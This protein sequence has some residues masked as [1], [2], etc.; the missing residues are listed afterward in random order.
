MRDILGLD[1]YSLNLSLA[2]IYR[3]IFPEDGKTISNWHDAG[4]DVRMTIRLIE[5][6][7]AKVSRSPVAGKLDRFLALLPNMP[8][9]DSLP[10]VETSNDAKTKVSLVLEIPDDE[11]VVPSEQEIAE[12]EETEPGIAEWELDWESDWESDESES[13]SETDLETDI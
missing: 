11:V 1:R 7:F 8:I 4:Y 12:M 5:F 2:N 3:L 9:S 13:E 10:K 6:Y